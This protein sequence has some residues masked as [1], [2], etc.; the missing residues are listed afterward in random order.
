MSE[1]QKLQNFSGENLI[2][3]IVKRIKIALGNNDAYWYE[4]CSKVAVPINEKGFDIAELD[5]YFDQHPPLAEI[6]KEIINCHPS[7]TPLDLTLQIPS[8]SQVICNLRKALTPL[9]F[10]LITIVYN[11]IHCEKHAE[12]V[13]YLQVI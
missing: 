1:T 6:A 2:T 5:F 12:I 13:I 9:G 4:N 7:G 8:E 3:E 11:D 10:H